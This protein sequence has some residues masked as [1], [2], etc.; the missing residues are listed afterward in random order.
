M[1]ARIAVMTLL[2]SACASAGSDAPTGDA[3]FECRG[4]ESRPCYPGPAVEVGVGACRE[5][6]QNCADGTFGACQGAV[7]SAAE[8]CGDSMDNDCNGEVD[9]GCPCT[10][11]LTTGQTSDGSMTCCTGNSTLSSISDCGNGSNHSVQQSGKCGIAH[12]GSGN[13]GSAC[14]AIVCQGTLTAGTCQ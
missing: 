8:V 11:T 13:G 4:N 7:T 10:Y 9:N 12:E 14:V 5:G 3:A 1:V 2:V 6:T